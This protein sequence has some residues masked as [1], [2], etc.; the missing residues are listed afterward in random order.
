MSGGLARHHFNEQRDNPKAA[1]IP[2]GYLA[3]R[4]PGWNLLHGYEPHECHVEYARLS[5]HSSATNLEN[6]IGSCKG[7]KIMV[8]TPIYSQPKGIMIPQYKE[9]IVIPTQSVISYATISRTPS[10][11]SLVATNFMAGRL[12]FSL[13]T[14]SSSEVVPSQRSTNLTT[15]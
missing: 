13:R 1:V 12:T 11:T 9:R 5:A 2:C 3:P 10:K 14:T 6:Y 7:K 4:T 8:H 15:T